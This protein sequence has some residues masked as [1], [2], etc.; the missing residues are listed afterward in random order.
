MINTNPTPQLP[1][2]L[3]SARHH[4]SNRQVITLETGTRSRSNSAPDHAA[5][6]H[7]FRRLLGTHLSEV[8]AVQ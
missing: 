5:I 3:K 2:T 4:A 6:R 1:S 7:L 8:S